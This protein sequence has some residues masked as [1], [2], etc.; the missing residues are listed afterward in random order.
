MALSRA[1]VRGGLWAQA[2]AGVVPRTKTAALVGVRAT[3]VARGAPVEGVTRG[4]QTRGIGFFSSRGPSDSAIRDLE[5]AA[6]RAP[7]D[8]NAE[9]R[10]FRALAKKYPESAI[11]RFEEG[12]HAVN[13][14]IAAE[15]IKAL[16]QR[17][18]GIDRVD[19]QG[20]FASARSRSGEAS[21]AT[22]G[23]AGTSAGA[24]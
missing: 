19:V 23:R 16:A 24:G 21:A 8:A 22:A 14:V 6:A 2:H 1:L 7:G 17:K 4:S 15:Y 10:F 18:G 12:R 9:A 3:R 20:I 11:Q 5:R 13:E